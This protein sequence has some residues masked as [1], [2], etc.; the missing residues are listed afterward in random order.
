MTPPLTHWPNHPQETVTTAESTSIQLLGVLYIILTGLVNSMVPTNGPWALLRK[1]LSHIVNLAPILWWAL[2][3]G[4]VVRL[5][6][7]S[8]EPATDWL[9]GTDKHKCLDNYYTAT[10]NSILLHLM[11]L[12]HTQ[13]LCQPTQVPKT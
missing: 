13:N 2:L 3:T 12:C 1:S 7:S 9:P 11:P 5:P 6:T 8:P 4:P 10:F